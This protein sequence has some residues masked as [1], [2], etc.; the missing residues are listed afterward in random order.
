MGA[1]SIGSVIGGFLHLGGHDVYMVGKGPHIEAVAAGGLAISGI[2][3]QHDVERMKAA[4]TVE[5]VARD[6]FEPEW[7]LLSVKSYDT[8][9][10]LEDMAALIPGQK[11]IASLQN[12]LGN[13]EEIAEAA[14]GKAIGGRVIFG[15]STLR[16]GAVEVTVCADDVL[17]GPAYGGPTGVEEVCDALDSSGIPCR[18]EEKILSYI[19]DKVLYNVAL[20]PLATVLRTNYGSLGDD[21]GTRSVIETLIGEFY[22]VAAA[23]GVELVAPTAPAYVERF[24]SDLLPPT[25]EHRSS[26]QEDIENGRPTEISALNGA[27]CGMA[28]DKGID[29]PANRLLTTLVEFLERRSTGG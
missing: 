2:W 17:L 8:R 16:P 12:G 11:G 6:G 15:A 22:K 19:W 14:P 24:F 23:E 4:S 10:A 29:V 1:G 7:T 21:S 5:Q 26:M 13:V 20:N 18:Y 27:V 9:R 25:R 3:G 28:S